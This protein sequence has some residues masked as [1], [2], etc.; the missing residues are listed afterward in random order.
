MTALLQEMDGFGARQSQVNVMAATNLPEG[1]DA[2]VL[3]RFDQRIFVDVPDRVARLELL[4]I[5]LRENYNWPHPLDLTA[6]EQE[7]EAADDKSNECWIENIAV[8][9]GGDTH[10]SLRAKF[11]SDKRFAPLLSK[12]RGWTEPIRLT[13]SISKSQVRGEKKDAGFL[14][15]LADATTWKQDQSFMDLIGQL[16][17]PNPNKGT[18]KENVPQRSGIEV[19]D[20]GIEQYGFTA[21]DVTKIVSN[22]VLKAGFRMLTAI[23]ASTKAN[24]ITQASSTQYAQHVEVKDRVLDRKESFWVLIPQDLREKGGFLPAECAKRI[25]PSS[26]V[27]IKELVLLGN[28]LNQGQIA[29]SSV[30][31]FDIRPSDL[32]AAIAEF[33]PSVKSCAYERL[34]ETQSDNC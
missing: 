4:K 1:L 28:V 22:A 2:A 27:D 9:S 32:L 24:G 14:Q 10:A 29:E 33:R 3:R 5:A 23:Q 31:S 15:R 21:S 20:M 18:A 17:G 34:F 6:E 8:F 25:I 26:G 11:G 13:D 16:L 7:Q 30:V 19:S 12:M